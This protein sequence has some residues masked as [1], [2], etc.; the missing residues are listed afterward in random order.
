MIYDE[1]LKKVQPGDILFSYKK[2]NKFSKL[3]WKM[4]KW[5]SDLE[6]EPTISHTFIYI[7]DDLVAEATIGYGSIIRSIFH[8]NPKTY[9]L[10]RGYLNT[11][12]DGVKLIKLAKEYSAELG[13]SYF[14]L[15]WLFFKRLFSIGKTVDEIAAVTCSEFVSMLFEEVGVSL[16]PGKN[17][18]EVSPL[19]IFNSH[20]I[21]TEEVTV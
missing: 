20:L 19:E 4:S 2:G 17:A 3:I 12:F 13:Y 9:V 21:I 18:S 8:Y 7:G 5:D 15:I 11:G 16:V 14:T 6:N 1:F 10:Y